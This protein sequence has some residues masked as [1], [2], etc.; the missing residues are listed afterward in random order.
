[1]RVDGRFAVHADAAERT[2]PVQ[3]QIAP[4][5]VVLLI[6]VVVLDPAAVALVVAI[7]GAG[8]AQPPAPESI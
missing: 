5:A 4:E 1:M 3:S 8:D 7:Q 6:A 2:V